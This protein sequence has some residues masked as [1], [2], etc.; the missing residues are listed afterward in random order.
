MLDGEKRASYKAHPSPFYLRL[1]PLDKIPLGVSH[2]E[3]F[4]I[5]MNYYKNV[6]DRFDNKLTLLT[7]HLFDSPTASDWHSCQVPTNK[8]F[9]FA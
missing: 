3:M 6:I 2:N 1:Q 8:A 7:L 4:K 9:N 5:R